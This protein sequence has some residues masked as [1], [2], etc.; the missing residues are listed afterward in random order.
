MSFT[1]G[2]FLT[3]TLIL[4]KLLRVRKTSQQMS[5]R[6][7]VQAS[8][9]FF[10]TRLMWTVILF[11]WLGFCN[12]NILLA[13]KYDDILHLWT[14]EMLRFQHWPSMIA[15]SLLVPL[16]LHPLWHTFHSF[17]P[18]QWI[19]FSLYYPSFLPPTLHCPLL[20]RL[21]SS[22]PQSSS[23]LCSLLLLPW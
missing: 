11:S 18:S 23:L 6:F 21:G 2:F 16:L 1:K 17:C 12:C 15:P 4:L 9:V 5:W 7:I 22:N 14:S 10:C 8:V 3:S 19:F 13:C 20:L